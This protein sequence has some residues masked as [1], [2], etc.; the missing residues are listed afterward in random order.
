MRQKARGG[1]SPPKRDFTSIFLNIR[2][3]IGLAQN[4]H[5]IWVEPVEPVGPVEI[6]K[7]SDFIFFGQTG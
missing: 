5:T 2:A 4:A 1:V 3:F 7:I 6:G